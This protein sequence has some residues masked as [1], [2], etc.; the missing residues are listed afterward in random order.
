[1]IKLK[2]ATEVYYL[3]G[4]ELNAMGESSISWHRVQKI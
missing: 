2:D 3:C 1:M 4:G